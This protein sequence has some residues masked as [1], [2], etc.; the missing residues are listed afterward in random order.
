MSHIAFEEDQAE[1]MFEK[2]GN[3]PSNGEI[4]TLGWE[5]FD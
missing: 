3:Q 4:P 2:L 1:T 5:N